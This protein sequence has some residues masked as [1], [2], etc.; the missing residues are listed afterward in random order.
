M[1]K[2]TWNTEHVNSQNLRDDAKTQLESILD[3]TDLTEDLYEEKLNI[4]HINN[5]V[6]LDEHTN[7][8][9]KDA[10]FKG[11]RK[12]I[13][14]KIYGESDGEMDD[15][16]IVILP[17][18]KR[19]FLHGYYN[20]ATEADKAGDEDSTFEYWLGSYGEWYKADIAASIVTM[21][22]NMKLEEKVNE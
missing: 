16:K 10:P 15:D 14:S 13:L 22:G 11:K 12:I 1:K 18:T 21:F 17:G 9:Y 2:V 19:V 5:L 20:H 7:K 8:E 4:Q 3:V 6:L